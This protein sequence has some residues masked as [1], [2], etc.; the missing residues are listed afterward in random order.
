MD[1]VGGGTVW[2]DD[3]TRLI[4]AVRVSGENVVCEI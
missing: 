4:G 3:S 2:G 1:G